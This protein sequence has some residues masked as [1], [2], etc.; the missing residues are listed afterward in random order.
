M[1]VTI[2]SGFTAGNTYPLNTPRIGWQ[3]I[4]G[5]IAASTEAAG[6]AAANAGTNRTDSF[7][8]PTA[9]PATWEIDAGSAQS[10]SYCGI[11][12]HD[13]GTQDCVVLVRS[14]PDGSTWT[15]RCT[16]TP[17]DDSAILALFGTVSARYW[18]IEVSGSGDEPT[19]GVIQFGAVT[20]FPQRATYAP[21]MSFER[22]RVASYSTNLSE[23][24]QW[25]GRSVSRVSLA[26]SMQVAHL[27][28]TWIAAEW[29]AFAEHAEAAP[30]FVAD[31]PDTFP[32]SCCYAWTGGDLRAERS[33]PNT[34]VAMSISLEMT[35]FLA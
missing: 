7:W 1:G 18:R 13:L 22:T 15:T 20:E 21:S 27:S 31:R 32:K 35:G 4:S 34:A 19:I 5:D 14:S 33:L 25:L 11:A 30:F 6:F 8:R 3:R 16:I 24:G 2:A 17:T 12:A 23:G 9:L 26:P 29:D 28:E 10:V